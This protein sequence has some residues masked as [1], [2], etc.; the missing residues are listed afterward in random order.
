MIRAVGFVSKEATS[1]YLSHINSTIIGHLLVLSLD[2]LLQSFAP[3]SKQSEQKILT[4][5]A[6]HQ[7][8]LVCGHGVMCRAQAAQVRERIPCWRC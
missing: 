7:Q 2:A 1:Q 6:L 4:D 8:A 3:K 5:L